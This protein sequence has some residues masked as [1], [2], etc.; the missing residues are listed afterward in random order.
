MFQAR[1]RGLHILM[2]QAAGYAVFPTV[3]KGAI[4]VGGAYGRGEVF[5]GKRLVGYCDLSQGSIGFQL[6]GQ[7]YRELILFQTPAALENFK[8]G[9]MQLAAQ[10]SAV[11]ATS[12]ASADADYHQGVMIFTMARGGLMYEASV[13]GQHFTY[14]PASN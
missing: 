8:S 12:G 9:A 1:D 13:G 11:A 5:T 10:A 3:G 14:V 4:G 6:G 7:T 2:D